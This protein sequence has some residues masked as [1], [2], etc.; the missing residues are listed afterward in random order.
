VDSPL[1]LP[2]ER[3]L[4]RGRT[5][6]AGRA[7]YALTD[8]RLVAHDERGPDGIIDEL[9]IQDIGDI[10]RTDTRLTRLFGLSTIVV[11]ARDARRQPLVLHRVRRGTQLAAILELVAGEPSGSLDAE[12]VRTALAWEPRGE[13]H[14]PREA[15]MV[16][17]GAFAAVFAVGVGLHGK[18]AGITYASDDAIYPGG[19][20]RD[21]AAIVRFMETSVMPWAREALGPIKGGGDKVTCETCHGKAPQ[22]RTWQMPAVVALPLPDMAVR[23]WETYSA[24]MDA[25]TRNAIYGYVAEADNQT[26]A[27]YMRE[28]VVPGMSRLLHR[29][30]YDFTKPYDYNRTRAAF[31]CYHCHR[32]T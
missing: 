4:W 9:L 25:Q 10:R 32:V 27:A 3:L 31:G 17:V 15:F 28:V 11:H 23:G 8:V 22:D 6:P 30:A 5:L 2:W 13:R 18:A 29:P 20:K 21:D 16:L 1:L 14:G 24:R 19:E 12:A 7:R 26:K